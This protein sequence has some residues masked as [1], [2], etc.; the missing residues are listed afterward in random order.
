[1]RNVYLVHIAFMLA[2]VGCAPS[3]PDPTLC[4]LAHDRDVYAGRAVT[5][6]GLLLVSRHG[7]VLVD[8]GCGSGIGISWF[9][10]DVPQMRE[11]DA[12][13]ERSFQQDMMVKARVTGRVVRGT[14]GSFGLPPVWILRLAKA[15]VLEAYPVSQAEHERFLAWLDGPHKEPFRP[16]R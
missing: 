5:V 2:I 16:T 10:E 7:S 3:S 9:E 13:A 6:E 14:A 15:E 1:M 11:F 12:L 8:P 4:E